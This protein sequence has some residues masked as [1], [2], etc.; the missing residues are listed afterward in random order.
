[1]AV[2]NCTHYLN[3]DVLG[4]IL[5]QMAHFLSMA[6]QISTSSMFHI[7]L[8]CGTDDVWLVQHLKDVHFTIIVVVILLITF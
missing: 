4:M 1:M 2:R 7:G 8:C 6:Q 5:L 3:K